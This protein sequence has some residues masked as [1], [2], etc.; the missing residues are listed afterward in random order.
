M[1]SLWAWL[2][3]IRAVAGAIAA[4]IYFLKWAGDM[5][6]ARAD[7]EAGRADEAAR[8]NAETAKVEGR[9][10]EASAKEMDEDSVIDR[11]TKGQG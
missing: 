7:R 6:Q 5:L 2:T 8:V 4:V 1:A 11:L 10:A 9:I 3:S